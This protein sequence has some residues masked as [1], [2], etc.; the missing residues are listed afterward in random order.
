MFHKVPAGAI[1]MLFDEQNHPFLENAGL[2]KYLGIRNIR[3]NFKELSSHHACLRFKI[4]IVGHISP[5]GRTKNPY[6]IFINL[7]SA[8]EITKKGAE[9]IQED[10]QKA[11]TDRENQIH[12]LEVTNEEH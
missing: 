9:K 6:D 11:I 12:A 3:D 2:A 8:I 10:H 4:E 1:E 7:D 5:L